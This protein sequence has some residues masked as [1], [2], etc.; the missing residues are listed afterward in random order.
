MLDFLEAQDTRDS[1]SMF[2][3]KYYQAISINHSKK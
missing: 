1:Y 3:P 2:M